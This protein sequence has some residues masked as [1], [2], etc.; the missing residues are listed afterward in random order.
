MTGIDFILVRRTV[1]DRMTSGR[2]EF[3]CWPQGTPP[4]IGLLQRDWQMTAT[5]TRHDIY[6]LSRL[7][8]VRLVKL[9]DGARLEVKSRGPDIGGLQTW[10]VPLSAAFPLPPA[11]LADVTSA[12]GMATMPDTVAM[13]SPAHL[14]AALAVAQARVAVLP[15]RKAR[16]SFRRGSCL[17]EVA[18]VDW[19][20]RHALTI[21]VEGE[22][23]SDCAAAIGDLGL[24]GYRN[25]SYG[26]MFQPGRLAAPI[27]R[28]H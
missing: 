16:L 27:T 8:D 4:A 23:P 21:A 14:L 26:E 22:D 1:P 11:A 7:S 25:L 28:P 17:A 20:G 15:V 5:E 24:A 2:L 19:L 18:R 9:R 12:L 10:G 6:L 3:R 13:L